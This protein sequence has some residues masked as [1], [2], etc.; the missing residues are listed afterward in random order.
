MDLKL[1]ALLPLAFFCEFIDSSLGMGYGTTL[2]PLLLVMGFEPLHVVPAVLF[3][4]FVSGLLA[5]FYHHNLRNVSFRADSVDSKVALV[6]SLFSVVGTF[7]AVLLAVHLSPTVMKIWIGIIVVS[8]ALIILFTLHRQ[9]HFSWVKI[10]LLGSIASFNKGM[11]GGGY[12]PVVMGGQILSGI[13]VKNA[14]GITSLAE[15]LTCLVGLVLYLL[16]KPD[17]NLSLAPWLMAGAILSVPFA[18]HTV[19]RISEKSMKM[20]VAAVILV[21]GILTFIK[22]IIRF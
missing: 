22:L 18:A 5:A 13:G 6:L 9:P 11:S 21:L 20:I 2:T 1:Y 7:A 12:G 19:R 8:M 17:I 4:E 16:L 3:S 15:G 14:I 10:T